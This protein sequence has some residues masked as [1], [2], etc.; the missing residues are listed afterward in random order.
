MPWRGTKDPYRIWLSEVMLQQTRVETVKRYWDRF[1]A[2][3]PTVTALAAAP[4]QAV[5]KAWEGLGYYRRARNLHQAA[6]LVLSQHAGEV[7]SDEASFRALPG[8]GDYTAGAVL[9][10]AFGFPLPAVDGNVVRVLCR[11]DDVHDD[12]ARPQAAS[13]LRARA[14]ALVDRRRPGD[15]TQ[16]VMELGATVCLPRE[17]R[18]LLCP[19]AAHCEGRRA[20][21]AA[22]LPRKVPRRAPHEWRHA[23]AV[24]RRAGRLLLVRRPEEGLL[25]GMWELPS[26]DIAGEPLERAVPR[27]LEQTTG[28]VA[29]YD[30]ELG[31]VDHAF[32]HARLTLAVCAVRAPRGRVRSNRAAWCGPGDLA[33]L[34][35]SVVAR[36]TLDLV[37]AKG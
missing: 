35:L 8:V 33:R 10:I 13:R 3:F 29:A 34:P 27:L 20:G 2:C 32:T 26:G 1:L 14:A 9:S 21:T 25:G 19:V 36:K 31:R 30:R 23:C 22:T 5:L 24:V 4:E 16:A 11:L 17:P 7:P 6:K 12:P 18:C 28:L 37:D 15:W